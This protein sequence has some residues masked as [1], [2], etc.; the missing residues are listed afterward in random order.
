MK[1]YPIALIFCIFFS[2]TA[3]SQENKR[4]NLETELSTLISQGEL[5]KAESVA[6]EIVKVEKKA[7]GERSAGYASALY[8][9]TVLLIRIIDIP[10]GDGVNTSV[11]D[12]NN[13]DLKRRKTV[14]KN[15]RSLMPLYQGALNEP[16]NLAKTQR[17]F[18]V[19]I[20]QKCEIDRSMPECV[21]ESLQLL[22]SAANFY[23]AQE[24]T[25]KDLTLTLSLIATIYWKRANFE[26]FLPAYRKYVAVVEKFG[27]PNELKG[28][29]AQ[30]L[31][32]IGENQLAAETWENYS[33]RNGKKGAPLLAHED[34]MMRNETINASRVFGKPGNVFLSAG[35]PDFGGDRRGIG[36]PSTPVTLVYD[37]KRPRTVNVTLVIDENGRAIEI[38][39][40]LVDEKTAAE[41]KERIA[42]WKFRP[43]VHEGVLRK[44]TGRIVAWTAP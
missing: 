27:R 39:P 26:E 23:E 7:T 2:L 20:Y 38:N 15:F 16:A 8:N 18:G 30:F 1:F 43:Y 40:G 21:K 31:F 6:E 19:Y 24:S 44:F 12:R 10:P 9:Y 4:T 34:L 29:Y 42:E 33:A 25:A 11:W 41:I 36:P 13:D 5:R 14:V 35:E 17:E 32:T 37:G 3:F 28:I 22:G